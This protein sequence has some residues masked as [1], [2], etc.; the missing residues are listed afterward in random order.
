MKF[1]AKILYKLLLHIFP[2]CSVILGFIIH[3]KTNNTFSVSSAFHQLADHPFCIKKIHRMGNVHDLTG[4]VNASSSYCFSQHLRMRLHHPGRNCVGRRTNDHI[5]SC[6]FHGVHYSFYVGEIKYA[7]LGLTGTPCRLRNP[8]SVDPCFFHHF[9]IFV[10]AVIWHIFVV[11]CCSVKKFFH[12]HPP[13]FHRLLLLIVTNLGSCLYHIFQQFIIFLIYNFCSLAACR[14]IF[15]MNKICS[16]DLYWS[17]NS[18]S[19]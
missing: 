8:D 4:A 7:W 5:D 19:H 9:H 18:D 16:S 2:C 1:F 3:L 12:V 15:F 10:Q 14:K 17:I 11:V 6:S 13:S